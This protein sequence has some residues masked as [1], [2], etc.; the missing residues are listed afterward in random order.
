MILTQKQTR[1]LSMLAEGAQNKDICSRLRIS[2]STLDGYLLRLRVKFGAANTT[3]LVVLFVQM[4][5]RANARG[6]AVAGK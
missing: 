3:R 2:K 5:T 1:I 4:G 6:R